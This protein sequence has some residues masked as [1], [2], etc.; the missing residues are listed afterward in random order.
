MCK[1]LKDN[2]DEVIQFPKTPQALAQAAEGF[3]QINTEH[4]F[5]GVVGCIDVTHIQIPGPLRDKTYYNR[6]GRHSIHLQAVCDSHL[7]FTDV[8]VGYPGSASDTTVYHESP[9]GK[10]LLENDLNMGDYHLLGDECFTLHRHL[11]TPYKDDGSLTMK[12]IQFNKILNSTRVLIEHAFARLKGTFERL[13]YCPSQKIIN[14]TNVV[15]A[16]C[17]LH[18]I[19]I[20]CGV[21]HYITSIEDEENDADDLQE[22]DSPEAVEKRDQLMAQLVD[23]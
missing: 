11:I 9:I 4:Q 6:Y 14:C 2:C 10:S 5:P 15:I 1:T 21:D 23:C 19:A 12:H 13:T 20:D 7:K 22:D 18:N 17:V 3:E 8:F 16:C